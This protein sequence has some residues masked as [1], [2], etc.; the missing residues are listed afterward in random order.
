MKI[1]W[2]VVAQSPGYKSLKAAYIRDTHEA[3][4]YQAR[5]RRPMR[6]KQEFLKLFQ[7]VIGRAQHYAVRQCRSVEEVLNEWEA[8]RTYWWLNYYGEGRQPKLP[9][10]KPRNVQYMKP[11]T[12][13]RQQRWH[14][15]GT[16][17]WFHDLR[18]KRA[19]DAQFTRKHHRGKKPR[20]SKEHKDRMARIRGYRQQSL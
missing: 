8:G 3:G 18:K 15:P 20:W 5:G 2:K 4:Q 11:D 16:K 13:H 6:S 9:S 10:G 12:Y 14:R 17:E 7:W 1:D 19:R